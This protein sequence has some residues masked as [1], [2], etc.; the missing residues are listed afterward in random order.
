MWLVSLCVRLLA[1]LK[2]KGGAVG[3]VW[4]ILCD[5]NFLFKKKFLKKAV[6]KVYEVQNP[7]IFCPDFFNENRQKSK[8]INKNSRKTSKI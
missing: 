3:M 2:R 5:G 7:K 4:C 1:R 6:S 8:K